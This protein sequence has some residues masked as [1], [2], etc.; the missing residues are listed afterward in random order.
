MMY[1]IQIFSGRNKNKE[2]KNPFGLQYYYFDNIV[3]RS[4]NKRSFGLWEK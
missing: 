3:N 4:M 2:K 1:K